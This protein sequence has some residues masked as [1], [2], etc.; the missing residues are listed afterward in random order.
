MRPET[1]VQRKIQGALKAC[2]YLS[3]FIP[4]RGTYNPRTRMYNIVTDPYF[5]KGVPDLVVLLLEAKVLWVEVK[6][7]TGKRSPAQDEMADRLARMGHFYV[8]AR[9]VSDVMTWLKGAGYR[10]GEIA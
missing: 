5:V 3:I 2:G 8:L 10:Y 6:S 7:A 1:I 9:S 4:N